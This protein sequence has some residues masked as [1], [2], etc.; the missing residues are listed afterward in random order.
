[1]MNNENNDAIVGQM[2]IPFPDQKAKELKLVPFNRDTGEKYE[3]DT[4]I[5]EL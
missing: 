2:V 4:I 3:A 5:I 1:M